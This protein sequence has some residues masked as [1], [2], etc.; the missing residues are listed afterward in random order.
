MTTKNPLA[1]SNAVWSS[2]KKAER[3]QKKLSIWARH[4]ILGSLIAISA[5]SIKSCRDN[6]SKL[7]SVEQE[8]K[9]LT[10]DL[11]QSRKD[12]AN[13]ALENQAYRRFADEATTLANRIVW[14]IKD[15]ANFEHPEDMNPKEVEKAEKMLKAES[16]KYEAERDAALK[17]LG[18][19]DEASKEMLMRLRKGPSLEQ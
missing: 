12:G 1:D 15:P 8:N 7:K 13:L 18:I 9:V 17:T 14:E 3:T 6:A 11:S 4:A 2:K 16:K 19:G 5:V 10:E